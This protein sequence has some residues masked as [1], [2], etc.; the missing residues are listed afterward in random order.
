MEL[1]S[2]F[3][4]SALPGF[5][6][7]IVNEDEVLFKHGFG[8]ADKAR[9]QA[10][11]T[12]TILNV[13]SV[14]K[15]VVGVAVVKAIQ[16]GSLTM[17]TEINEILP[18]LVINPYYPTIPILLRHLCSHS[19]TILDSRNYRFTYISDEDP[20]EQ[21]DFAKS[22]L[23]SIQ[24]HERIPLLDF[25]EN[26]LS[27]EG[28]WY[29]NRNFAKDKPGANRRYSNLNAALAAYMIQT[30]TAKPFSFFCQEQIFEPLEMRSSGWNLD[31]IDRN[32]FGMRYFP[33]GQI[34]PGYSLITYPD[35][36]FM[37]NVSDLANFLKAIM[38]VKTGK[39]SYLNDKYANI[40]L[41]GDG[42]YDHAF[43]GIEEKTGNIGLSGSD[44][45][46]QADIQFNPTNKIGRVILTNVN[47]EEDTELQEQYKEIFSILAK[48]EALL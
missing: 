33:N 19:S 30:A 48:Y 5:A 17:D 18:F 9:K 10:F 4:R 8:Y 37:T 39:S 44:P 46:V 32:K 38:K 45:G 20:L 28:K 26:I 35:G 16:D 29:K 43:W 7:A 13:G 14:S 6:V 1:D 23:N 11:T 12:E 2:H 42:D 34:V 31:E 47:S 3:V 27:S 24:H 21:T 22:F 36:G 41:P 40:L 15:A 25:L